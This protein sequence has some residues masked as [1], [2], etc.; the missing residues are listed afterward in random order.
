MSKQACMTFSRLIYMTERWLASWQMSREGAGAGGGG[1]RSRA[2]FGWQ[3]K[4]AM[5][6]C[7]DGASAFTQAGGHERGGDRKVGGWWRAEVDHSKH[8][9][10]H[11]YTHSQLGQH[12]PAINH[13]YKLLSELCQKLFECSM[14]TPH[15]TS[16]IF[17]WNKTLNGRHHVFTSTPSMRVK[18][19]QM[20]SMGLKWDTFTGILCLLLFHPLQPP[21]FL[22]FIKVSFRSHPL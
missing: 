5:R 11:M 17:T 12:E 4:G 1:G 19:T 16:A 8:T 3:T 21:G 13:S 14:R 10:M 20:S 6:R 22:F 15:L 18:F 9:R 2:G 7:K